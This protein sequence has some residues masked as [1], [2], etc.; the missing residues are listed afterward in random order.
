MNRCEPEKL[1]AIQISFIQHL[2]SPLFHACA[3][4]GIIPGV[5][6][7]FTFTEKELKKD[8]SV[9]EE[10]KE[11]E[12]DQLQMPVPSDSKL[13]AEEDDDPMMDI[14]DLE[15]QSVRKVFSIILTNLQ[16]NFKGWQSELPPEDQPKEQATRRASNNATTEGQE[17]EEEEE[18]DSFLQHS[19]EPADEH[20]S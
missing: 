15:A 11:G 3:E 2:V 6:E 14:S 8:E 13:E 12:R 17:K 18:D 1:P 5:V 4:A 9:E 19:E 7:S 16:V 10:E 20:S